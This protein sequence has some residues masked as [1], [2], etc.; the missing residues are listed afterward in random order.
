MVHPTGLS[1]SDHTD[2]DNFRVLSILLN[3]STAYGIHVLRM[4]A[5]RQ[6]L[7]FWPTTLAQWEAREKDVTSTDGVYALRTGLPHPT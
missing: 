1:L 7:L 5:L 3:L 6:L 4:K 2:M